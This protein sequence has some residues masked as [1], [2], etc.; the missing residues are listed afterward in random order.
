MY[1]LSNTHVGR[2]APTIEYMSNLSNNL[3]RAR[4]AKGWSQEE[5]AKKAGVSQGTIGHLESGR[6]TSSRKLPEIA[7]ALGLTVEE[8]VNGEVRV[9]NAVGS[10][11]IVPVWPFKIPLGKVLA[12]PVAKRERIEGFMVA[13]VEQHEGELNEK[14]STRGDRHHIQAG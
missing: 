10:A 2:L 7:R 3:I 12:L 1:L 9:Q 6:N 4:A 14:L 8:L 13:V 5:L 11:E